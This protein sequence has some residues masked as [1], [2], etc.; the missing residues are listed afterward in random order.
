MAVADV[1]T[2]ISEDRPYRQGMDKN[3]IYQVFR[4]MV[5]EEALDKRIVDLLFDNYESIND[6]VKEKQTIALE[7]YQNKFQT[8]HHRLKNY[9]GL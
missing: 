9:P 6:H 8:F 7:F 2:A 1:F 3:G 4:T 5:G